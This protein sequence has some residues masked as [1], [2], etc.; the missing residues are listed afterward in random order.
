MRAVPIAVDI[1]AQRVTVD[2]EEVR[3]SRK[4][5]QLLVCLL[6][7]RG[8]TRSRK[9]LLE[10]VWDTTADLDHRPNRRRRPSGKGRFPPAAR[11][12]SIGRRKSPMVFIADRSSHLAGASREPDCRGE[13]SA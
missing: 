3:L 12:R 8:R 11:A 13:G 5:F 1:N 7:R 6:S 9:A 4:E 2:E 10:S